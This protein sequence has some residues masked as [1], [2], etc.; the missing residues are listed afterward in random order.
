MTVYP[1][2]FFVIVVDGFT[3]HQILQYSTVIKIKYFVTHIVN[4]QNVKKK[5][6]EVE[7]CDTWGVSSV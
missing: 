5:N 1:K 3:C 6:K 7:T 4:C 2:G